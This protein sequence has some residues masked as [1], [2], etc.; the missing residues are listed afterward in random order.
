MHTNQII[1][2][3]SLLEYVSSRLLQGD[4]TVITLI[5]PAFL[6]HGIS[7][8]VATLMLFVSNILIPKTE[9][10]FNY[11]SQT[12]ITSTTQFTTLKIGT[13]IAFGKYN[14]RVL[15]IRDNA[16]LILSENIIEERN[17]HETED[18]ITW[19]TCNLRN[20]LN[21]KFIKTFTAEEQAHIFL[22]QIE[23]PSN[24][25][26]NT[27]GCQTTADRIFILSIQEVVR[28]FSDSGQLNQT[29]NEAGC[30]D[31]NY[32]STRIAKDS[33]GSSSQWWLRSSGI[34]PLYVAYV[35]ADG[36]IVVEGERFNASKNGGV[37]PALW[38]HLEKM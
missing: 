4:D 3:F 11:P 8:L 5:T 17:Y 37:R 1:G 12:T 16:V 26:Y 23:N 36:V 18:N 35:D 7:T 34:N 2:G 24:P 21:E 20:Y 10:T 31:D 6:V 27:S 30:I 32:N 25:W 13:L 33:T 14:W 28:Y 9:N 15:E 19:E 29:A 38:L 22:A